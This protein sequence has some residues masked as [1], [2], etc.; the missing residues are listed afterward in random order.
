MNVLRISDRRR[1]LGLTLCLCVLAFGGH[2][3][4][5]PCQQARAEEVTPETPDKPRSAAAP[6]DKA[7][8]KKIEPDRFHE[9]DDAARL[10]VWLGIASGFGA[11]VLLTLIVVGARRLRRLTRSTALK[12]KY[13]ELELLRAKYRRE[14]EGLET[15]PPSNRE[16]RR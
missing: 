4:A 2:G 16:A 5:G 1:V 8:G 15:P 10:L 6:D 9:V 12:S 11:V 14:M 13:D 3:A 7:A